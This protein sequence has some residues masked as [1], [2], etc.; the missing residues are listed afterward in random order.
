MLAEVTPLLITV[1]EVRYLDWLDMLWL[2]I[3]RRAFLVSNSRMRGGGRTLLETSYS[4]K[5]WW[6]KI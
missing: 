5:G 4:W 1:F 3:I 6:F 2:G